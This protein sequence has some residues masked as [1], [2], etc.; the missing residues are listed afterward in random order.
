MPES[1]TPAIFRVPQEEYER[2]NMIG[3]GGQSIV[4][5]CFKKGC[6][7][8]VFALKQLR[9]EMT[10][11]SRKEL[12][13]EV[14]MIRKVNHIHVI[15]VRGIAYWKEFGIEYCGIILEPLVDENPNNL[16]RYLKMH[17][18]LLKEK[19]KL[20]DQENNQK[21]DGWNELLMQQRARILSWIVCL[22]NALH[23]VHASDIVHRDIKLE[24][25]LIHQGQV[26]LTDFGISIIARNNHKNA[27]TRTTATAVWLAP[28]CF[29]KGHKDE[30]TID[31]ITR[32]TQ[33]SDIFALGCVFSEMLGSVWPDDEETRDKGI[34]LPKKPVKDSESGPIKS[35]RTFWEE[36]A[37]ENIDGDVRKPGPC[38]SQSYNGWLPQQL[39]DTELGTY[40][41]KRP[42]HSQKY[43]QYFRRYATKKLSDL[44]GQLKAEILVD[45]LHIPA[46]AVLMNDWGMVWGMVDRDLTKRSTARDV[47][48][49]TL[50]SRRAVNHLA[51]PL[52]LEPE[53]EK[54]CPCTILSRHD[55][56]DEMDAQV[57]LQ[58]PEATNQASLGPFGN[59]SD[60]EE[61]RVIESHQD[62]ETI[63]G[64]EPMEHVADNWMYELMTKNREREQ[65]L[66][67]SLEI[68]TSRTGVLDFPL[69]SNLRALSYHV[70]LYN[71]SSPGS[72]GEPHIT[73]S[74]TSKILQDF[75]DR[76]RTDIWEEKLPA[77]LLGT[78]Y[79]CRSNKYPCYCEK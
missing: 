64:L 77:V 41:E 25:I 5:K 69:S 39:G 59:Q 53:P 37:K 9:Y 67:S 63:E 52:E 66:S 68:C 11:E 32:Q 75:Y 62:P 18:H 43:F 7:S 8:E 45:R 31:S 48:A 16:D 58:L 26:I 1:T 71:D 79:N 15:K 70:P 14:A 40:L 27:D 76:N 60:T 34:S 22:A 54:H 55:L 2:G 49:Y 3:Y 57:Q 47:L 61:A 4:Y 74:E 12:Q 24:N 30:D 51:N 44:P 10:D 50:N 65:D 20:R 19:L 6:P 38:L 72:S 46:L 36:R 29:P 13:D 23:H 33:G 28:E 42:F 73:T 17:T 21:G 56:W 35:Y 78:C